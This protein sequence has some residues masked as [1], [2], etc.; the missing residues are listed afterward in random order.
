MLSEKI[1]TTP[2]SVDDLVKKCFEAG[3]AR[4]ETV[5]AGGSTSTGSLTMAVQ[6]TTTYASSATSKNEIGRAVRAVLSDPPAGEAALHLATSAI[7]STGSTYPY[8]EI[9]DP[10]SQVDVNFNPNGIEHGE[11]WDAFDPLMAGNDVTGIDWDAFVVDTS[12]A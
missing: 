11:A 4:S 12:F 7:D 1:T 3:F 5:V 6:P 8:N 2:L 10:T 9:F